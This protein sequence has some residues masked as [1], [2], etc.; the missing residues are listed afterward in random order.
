MASASDGTLFF[1]D[2]NEAVDRVI[3]RKI[4]P[5]GI[6]STILANEGN[7]E[8]RYFPWAIDVSKNGIVYFTNLGSD[9]NQIMRINQNGVIDTIAGC[10]LGF[11][12][13]PARSSKF[14][15]MLAIA[16][17][18][19]GAIYVSDTGNQAIRKIQNGVVSTIATN[20]FATQSIDIGDDGIIYTNAVSS[21]DPFNL[22]SNT[23]IKISPL[24]TIS[25]IVSNIAISRDIESGP[26]GRLFV[27]VHQSDVY[28]ISK[29][30]NLNTLFSLGNDPTGLAL[31]NNTLFVAQ[32]LKPAITKVI[33]ANN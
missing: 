10:G 15:I 11:E 31:V 29:N 26:N 21:K 28:D 9:N 18:D 2:L 32:R 25:T 19:N 20:L 14:N 33:L 3:I 24:G 1:T 6:V 7:A 17:G 5:N 30:G 23:I 13:G 12:D 8:S 27:S 4:L 16:V 22:L